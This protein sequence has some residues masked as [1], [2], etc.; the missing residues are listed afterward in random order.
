MG[1]EAGRG[2]IDIRNGMFPSISTPSEEKWNQWWT[3][4]RRCSWERRRVPRS[5]SGRSCSWHLAK[6]THQ[7]PANPTRPSALL[8]VG[9]F[10]AI[11]VGETRQQRARQ[12]GRD[13]ER[14]RRRR[15]RRAEGEME[16]YRMR[17]N[18]KRFILGVWYCLDHRAHAKQE[19]PSQHSL[20]IFDS[21]HISVSQPYSPSNVHLPRFSSPPG[22]SVRKYSL[23]RP[24]TPST[25]RMRVLS[26]VFPAPIQNSTLSSVLRQ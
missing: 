25:P 23:D 11:R 18:A 24:P 19:N 8:S 20:A 4:H 5:N 3:G 22:H 6:I 1:E 15:A 2:E 12:R 17:G 16:G 14:W 9:F 13:G 26:R 10:A 21:P 7:S